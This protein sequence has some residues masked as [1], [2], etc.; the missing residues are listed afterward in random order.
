MKKIVFQILDEENK[1][2]VEAQNMKNMLQKMNEL[3]IL[4]I[5]DKN[6]L[7]QE[8]NKDKQFEGLKN[9]LSIAHLSLK[10]SHNIDELCDGLNKIV[11]ADCEKLFFDNFVKIFDGVSVVLSCVALS[12]IDNILNIKN[13]KNE[14]SVFG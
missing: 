10:S 11:F 6:Y 7:Y 12:V 14:F 9:Q 5:N 8:T 4:T 1:G 13:E 3:R 2:H